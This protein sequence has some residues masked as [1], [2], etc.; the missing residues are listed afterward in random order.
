MNHRASAFA[1]TLSIGHPIN[2][3]RMQN[4]RAGLTW[5]RMNFLVRIE[6]ARDV[7]DWQWLDNAIDT[8]AAGLQIVMYANSDTKWLVDEMLKW[9]PLMPLAIRKFGSRRHYSFSLRDR[10]ECRHCH[11]DRQTLHPPVFRH[12][13]QTMNMAA[14]IP[15]SYCQSAGARFQ[16]WLADKYGSIDRLNKAWGTFSGQ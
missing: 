2:G 7:F 6:P 15:L 11:A 1:I 5:V 16:Q 10:R 3:N 8:L 12:G 14:M 13:R 9:L 4:M